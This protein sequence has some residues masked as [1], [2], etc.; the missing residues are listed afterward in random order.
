MSGPE[1]PKIIGEEWS[2]ERVRSFLDL[3]PYREDLD[4]DYFVLLRAYESM[5]AEDFERFIKFFVESGRNLNAVNEQ[6][7]T[8]LDRVS[9]HRRS[10]DYARTLK[11]A[12]A[13]KSAGAGT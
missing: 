13:K 11:Q 6:G 3:K 7:E 12:G 1:K 2:D 8:I 5:R 4:A 9:E 10:I